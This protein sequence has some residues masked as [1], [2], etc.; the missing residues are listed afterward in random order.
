[1]ILPPPFLKVLDERA[2]GSG[3]KPIIA[4]TMGDPGGVGPEIILKALQQISFKKVIPLLIGSKEGFE[5]ASQE[6]KISFR[7]HDIPTLERS[8]LADDQINFLDMANEAKALYEKAFGEHHPDKEAFTIGTVSRWNGVLAYSSLKIAAYQAA[9]GLVQAIVT[10]PVSKQAIRLIDPKFSGHTEY[11][12]KVAGVQDFA[13]MFVS[14]RLRVTLV[15][16]HLALGEVPHVLTT[17]DIVSK[18][19][20]T[21][22]F[23]RNHLK[24]SDP[25]IGVSALNPHG[26]EFGTEEEKII[27]PAVQ[28]ALR[29]GLK[30]VGPLAGDQIFYEGYTGRFDAIIAMYHDQGLAPF[31]MIAFHDGVNVTLGLPYLRSSPDHGTAFDIAYQN[32]ANPASF[33]ASFELLQKLL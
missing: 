6:L 8:L 18:I 22:R 9:C 4:L 31:K 1:M 16:T 21:D 26:S 27:T 14:E 15:T 11:L 30:V 24:I 12:A 13:M 7:P 20:L 17:Q 19:T 29:K 25:T 28:E 33:R 2:G 3:M 23:L 10:A 32:K 5:F